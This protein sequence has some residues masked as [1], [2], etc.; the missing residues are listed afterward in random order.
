[1]MTVGEFGHDDAD[2]T[3]I[4]ARHHG[5]CVAHQRI[6]GVAVVHR[7]DPILRARDADDLPG[8]RQRR[9]QRLL[10]QYIEACFEKGARDL[11]M[12]CVGRSDGHQRQ[13]VGVRLLRFQ[14]LPPVAIGPIDASWKAPSSP[15]AIRCV[16]PIWLPSPP[17]IN[18][19]F[20]RMLQA[21]PL[22]FR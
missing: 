2:V 19:Q 4:A 1:M 7:A 5:A 17:P 9:G 16:A 18:P 6:A 15:A 14:H 8:F 10:A 22:D 12:R 20:N 11:E 13:A 21:S 3:Q